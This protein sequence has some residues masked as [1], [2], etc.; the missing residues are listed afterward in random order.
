M[1][2]LKKLD[3]D[4]I[5]FNQAYNQILNKRFIQVNNYENGNLLFGNG[6][7]LIEII[8]D[9]D[10]LEL[11]LKRYSKENI[12]DEEITDLNDKSNQE[13]IKIA[14]ENAKKS[15]KN[16]I[17][18]INEQTEMFETNIS[19]ISENKCKLISFVEYLIAS[20]K[21]FG[22]FES[23]IQFYFNCANITKYHYLDILESIDI[24]ALKFKIIDTDDEYTFRINIYEANGSIYWLDFTIYYA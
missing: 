2:N 12:C 10:L 11:I 1:V 15:Y 9:K 21:Y 8:G 19:L 24:T 4:K 17:S 13:I 23:D 5:P 7:E 6:Y 20:N 3:L 18:Y 16:N 22:G 14:L